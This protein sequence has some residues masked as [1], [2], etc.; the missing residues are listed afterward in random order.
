MV[1]ERLNYIDQAKGIAIILVVVGHLVQWNFTGESCK[2]IFDYIYSFNMPLFFF[3]SGFLAYKSRFKIESVTLIP[4]FKKRF[5]GLALPFFSWGLFV[6]P[7]VISGN[8]NFK[9]L[10]SEWGRNLMFPEYGYW[11]LIVLF[12]M[13]VY[14][15]VACLLSNFIK[16]VIKY[17]FFVKYSDELFFA[18]ILICIWLLSHFLCPSRYFSSRYLIMFFM[19]CLFYKYNMVQRIP[20]YG[21]GIMVIIFVLLAPLWHFNGS[22]SN[23]AL[24]TIISLLVSPALLCILSYSKPKMNRISYCG[25]NSLEIYIIHM[26]FIRILSVAVH[27]NINSLFLMILLFIVGYILSY[28]SIVIANIFKTIPY[29]SILL[30]GKK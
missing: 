2:V 6:F 11:F 9:E 16:R 30:F 15:V 20:K 25:T 26:L 27:I 12:C 18:I 28:I 10:L 3:I 14:Y 7:I 29:C 1:G 19:G 17:R 24:S 22:E 4:L 8:S 21:V 5:I 23:I 13:H